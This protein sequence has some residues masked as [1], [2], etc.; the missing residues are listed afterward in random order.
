MQKLAQENKMQ[1]HIL[2]GANSK[3]RWHQVSASLAQ[4][5][6]H[7]LRSQIA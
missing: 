4:E 3:P 2:A 1:K 6:D 5:R 7:R